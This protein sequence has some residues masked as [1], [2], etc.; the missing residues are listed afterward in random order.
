MSQSSR[1]GPPCLA[2]PNDR[3]T[4]VELSNEV[5]FGTRELKRFSQEP[6]LPPRRTSNSKY[7]S[8][9]L[10][11]LNQIEMANY[12]PI[13]SSELSDLVSRSKTLIQQLKNE[14]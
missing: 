8:E 1:S 2:G 12:S 10:Y 7:K 14:V 4:P 9:V 11:I 5:V 3:L 6:D 13:S